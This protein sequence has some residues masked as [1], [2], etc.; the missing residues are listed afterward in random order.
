MRN[1]NRCEGFRERDLRLSLESPQL[2]CANEYSVEFQRP[3]FRKP[4]MSDGIRKSL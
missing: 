3:T 4:R 1:R 2:D